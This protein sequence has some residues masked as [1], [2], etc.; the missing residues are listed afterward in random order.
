VRLLQVE[1]VLL[2]PSAQEFLGDLRFGFLAPP[3]AELRQLGRVALAADNGRDDGHPG[4]AVDIGHRMV[5]ADVHL[6]A[7]LLHLLDELGARRDQVFLFTQ[8]CPHRHDRFGRTEGRVKQPAAV[9]PLQP[10]AVLHV[11]LAPGDHP[12]F[13][14]VD[15]HDLDAVRFEQVGDGYPVDAGALQRDG[16]DRTLLEPREQP[17]KLGGR[18]PEMRGVV[19][20][21]FLARTADVVIRSPRDIDAR[22]IAA[23]L[24]KHGM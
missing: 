12:H 19:C 15:E 2:A 8:Q 22:H 23:G 4:R 1:Q 18:R 5:D 11:A 13:A 21:V 24:L 7:A 9:K 17:V 14:R 6:V 3:V 20:T 16:F 10:L